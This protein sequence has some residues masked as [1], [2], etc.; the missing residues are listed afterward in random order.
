M[1]R[2]GTRLAGVILAVLVLSSACGGQAP[3]AL[4]PS[5]KATASPASQPWVQDLTFSGELNGNLRLIAPS[6]PGQQSECTGHNARGGS[7]WAATIYGSI[8]GPEVWALVMVVRGYRGA[9]S[10]DQK[11]ASVQVHSQDNQRGWQSFYA[12]PVAFAIL[13]G[14]ESGTVDATLSNLTTGKPSLKVAGKWS[15]KA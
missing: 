13:R 3:K 5:P 7:V 14:E 15:C 10:Y 9:G 6:G 2:P 8:G 11:S 12:N 4:S 1:P